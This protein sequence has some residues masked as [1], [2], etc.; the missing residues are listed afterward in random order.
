[1]KINEDI[2]KLQESFAACHAELK[3]FNDTFKA[4]ADDMTPKD[5]E[6]KE[7]EESCS[8]ED[9]GKVVDMVYR[10]ADSLYSYISMVDQSSFEWA[11]THQKGHLPN[12][13]TPSQ[14][15]KAIKVLGMG[16]DYEVQKTKISVA[17]KN[18]YILE[19][20]MPVK[21]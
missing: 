7:D 15:E 20:E 17:G 13:K 18:N 16:E 14:L 5:G 12:A 1:M 10:M 6:D 11:Q 8:K 2:K 3:K 4:K 9:L 21:H 19:V